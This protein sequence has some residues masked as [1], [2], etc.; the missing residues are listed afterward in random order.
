MTKKGLI[1]LIPLILIMSLAWFCIA[2]RGPSK[3]ADVE[4]VVT[5]HYE[6]DKGLIK[7]YGR[8]DTI[9]YLSESI[10][11]YLNYLLLIGNKTEFK[12]QVKVLQDNFWVKK[13]DQSFLKWELA[14]RTVTNASVDE[15]RIIDVLKRAAVRFDKA[16]YKELSVKLQTA[17]LAKQM[18]GGMIVDFYDWQQDKAANTVH[19]SYINYEALKTMPLLNQG[20]Y[21]KVIKAAVGTATPFFNEI[22]TIDKQSYQAAD[23]NTVNLIDQLLIAIQYRKMV[24]EASKAFDHWLKTE[25]DTKGKLYGRYNQQ[26]LAPAVDY[27]SSAVYAL[28]LDYFIET[29]NRQYAKRLDAILLKQPPFDNRADFKHMHFFDYIYA[30]TADVLYQQFL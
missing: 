2:S 1:M 15:L 4:K 20:L 6:T 17:L 26:T 14:R 22:Y 11:Q 25:I 9:Q 19:L 16:S 3:A 12:H 29:D 13:D 27:E 18:K 5:K 28:A 23:P 24:G 8:E 30:R 21:K 7:S 10:G